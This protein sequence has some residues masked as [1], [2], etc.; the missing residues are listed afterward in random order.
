MPTITLS[1]ACA[2]EL[3]AAL[4]ATPAVYTPV[5]TIPPVI[6]PP[7]SAPGFTSVVNYDMAWGGHF[8]RDTYPYGQTSTPKWAVV[9]SFTAGAVGT[10][11]T[12]SV[13]PYPGTMQGC[14]RACAISEIPGDFSKPGL[15]TRRGYDA[16]IQAVVGPGS[17]GLLGLNPYTHYY[18][19]FASIDENG[20]WTAPD[21]GDIRLEITTG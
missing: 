8:L 7:A 6:T 2:S 9:V 10:T 18:L 12:A 4:A 20:N 19:N 15:W 16:G 13:A 17:R 1:D 5:V 11:L 3:R 14:W 21:A